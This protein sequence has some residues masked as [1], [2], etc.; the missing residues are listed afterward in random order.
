[1]LKGSN[2]EKQ[3]K[4]SKYNMDNKA[5]DGIAKRTRLFTQ[6]CLMGASQWNRKEPGNVEKKKTQHSH[7]R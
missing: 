3:K 4:L 5:N 1:M 7:D 2:G 6:V